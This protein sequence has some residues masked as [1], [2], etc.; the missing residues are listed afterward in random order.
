MTLLVKKVEIKQRCDCQLSLPSLFFNS[1]LYI[2]SKIEQPASAYKAK[3]W[4][5]RGVWL[6]NLIK[7]KVWIAFY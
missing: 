2:G 4:R 1:Q 7:Y 3:F 5:D 6:E